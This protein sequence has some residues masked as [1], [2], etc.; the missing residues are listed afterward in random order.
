MLKIDGNLRLQTE[1]D[2]GYVAP[3]NFHQ[4]FDKIKISNG[5]KFIHDGGEQKRV[6]TESSSNQLAAIRI[7]KTD[8]NKLLDNKQ[9][10]RAES[11]ELKMVT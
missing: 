5:V 7:T 4:L 11:R 3:E 1:I 6:R 2:T 10:D 9:D 8:Y